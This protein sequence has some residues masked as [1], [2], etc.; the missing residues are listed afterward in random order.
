MARQLPTPATVPFPKE[1]LL[2]LWKLVTPPA[3]AAMFTN[4][5][6]PTLHQLI[7]KRMSIIVK[8]YGD[9]GDMNQVPYTDSHEDMRLSEKPAQ[10]QYQ[11]CRSPLPI[12][13]EIYNHVQVCKCQLVL[14]SSNQNSEVNR[15]IAIKSIFKSAGHI[16]L[17]LYRIVH[18]F[19]RYLLGRTVLM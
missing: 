9:T 3:H 8:W 15:P 17:L 4:I 5:R 6:R 18:P 13:V 11:R 1:P 10:A 14:K 19:G 2:R 12:R 16:G 7:V